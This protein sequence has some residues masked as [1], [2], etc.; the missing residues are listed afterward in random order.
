MFIFKVLHRFAALILLAG[1][2]LMLLFTVFAGSIEHFPFNRFYWV[3]ADTSGIPSANAD[4][5]RWTF[6][7]ICHPDS[8]FQAGTNNCPGLGA[9]VP[10]S[11]LDNFGNSTGIPQDFITNRDTYYYLSR[12]SFPFLLLALIFTGVALLLNIFAICSKSMKQASFVMIG[13]GC[14]FCTVGACLITAVSALTRNHFKDAGYPAKL[15][16]SGFGL[17]WASTFILMVLG[18]ASCFAVIRK[19]KKSQDEYMESNPV[20]ATATTPAYVP[21]NDDQNATQQHEGSGIRFFKIRRNQNKVEQDSL[22]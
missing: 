2:T 4:V 8:Y 7:G 5:T 15:N 21:P 16:A 12:F 6:W 19:A 20:P 9:D 18:L 14:L 17:V 13:L 1:A 11:P 3:Q 10:I 22:A